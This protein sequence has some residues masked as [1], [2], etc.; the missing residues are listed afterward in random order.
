MLGMFCALT[1]VPIMNELQ[2]A[3]M[4]VFSYNLFISHL[5]TKIT[6]RTKLL[7]T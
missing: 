1:F 2:K 4:Q 3:G 6:V 7:L 5:Y